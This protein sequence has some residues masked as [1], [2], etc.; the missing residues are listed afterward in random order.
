M[1]AMA[2]SASEAS[3]VAQEFLGARA[4][5]WEPAITHIEDVGSWWRVSYN[6]RVFV[7]TGDTNHVLAG[8]LPLLV[9]KSSRSIECDSSYLPAWRARVSVELLTAEVG[10]RRR[11]IASGYRPAWR[12]DRKPDWNDA[13]LVLDTDRPLRPGDVAEAWLLPG[14]PH[15]W[16]GLILPGDVLEGAEGS[17]AVARATVRGVELDHA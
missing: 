9:D 4:S 6:S 11:G 15:L 12:S 13:A 14:S 10:G 5:G 2:L 16:A 7:E 1:V 3:A 8:N 17:R